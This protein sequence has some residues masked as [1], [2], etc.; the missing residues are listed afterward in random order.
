MR[1]AFAACT[2]AECS[3]PLDPLGTC[4][5]FQQNVKLPNPRLNSDDRRFRRGIGEMCSHM[6]LPL[7]K[8]LKLPL[9]HRSY[10]YL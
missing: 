6:H 3:S 4:I 7:L 8:H 2:S 5:F 9:E 1:I 10:F